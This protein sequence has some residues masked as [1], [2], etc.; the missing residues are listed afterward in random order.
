MDK[1][2]IFKTEEYDDW[3]LGKSDKEKAQIS[4]RLDKI[5]RYGYFGD[6]R[7]L[8]DDIWELKWKNGRRIYY[9]YIE[10]QNILLLLGGNK[11]GQDKDITQARKILSKKIKD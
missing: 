8:E 11:N 7:D 5:E 10:E 3:F 6:I 1:Y 9:A 2:S 4:S